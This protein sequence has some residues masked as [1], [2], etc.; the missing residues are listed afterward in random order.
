MKNQNISQVDLMTPQEHL[1]CGSTLDFEPT[2][3]EE[4]KWYIP[5]GV[6]EGV[7]S[8]EQAI[9]GRKDLGELRSGSLAGLLGFHG[10][11][12]LIISLADL[13]EQTGKTLKDPE[14]LGIGYSGEKGTR[15]VPGRDL[16]TELYEKFRKAG[17]DLH[18][19]SAQND[20]ERE[21]GGA[22]SKG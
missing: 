5:F 2:P 7:I 10:Y 14:V 18:L 20:K 11:Q 4:G 3:E 8:L 22:E 12:Q 9:K 21:P 13:D 16:T 1:L 6:V 15:P 17:I 19:R